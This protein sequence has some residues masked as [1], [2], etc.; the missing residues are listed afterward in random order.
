MGDVGGLQVQMFLQQ[1]CNSRAHGVSKNAVPCNT[2][3]ADNTQTKERFMQTVFKASVILLSL[4]LAACTT[5]A[6]PAKPAVPPPA[7]FGATPTPAQVKHAARE[8]YAFCHFTVDTFTDREWGT[9]IGRAH[10]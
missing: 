10:V 5:A 3:T 7:P 9:E 4:Q 8:F 2:E 6:P 1:P